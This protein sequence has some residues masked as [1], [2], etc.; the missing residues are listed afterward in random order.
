M[1][2]PA[3]Q[4]AAGA[5]ILRHQVAATQA[6]DSASDEGNQLFQR[7]I[8]SGHPPSKIRRAKE[9]P[10]MPTCTPSRA[11]WAALV[12]AAAVAAGAS[13]A[14]VR[15]RGGPNPELV[16]IEVTDGAG[17]LVFKLQL[18]GAEFHV[19]DGTG[20]KLGSIR[21]EGDRVKAFNPQMKAVGKLKQK[22]DGYK[23]YREPAAAGQ[24]DVEL[25]KFKLEDGRFK[26][27]DAQDRVLADAKEAGG[28][29]KATGAAGQR[30]TVKRKPDGVEVEDAAGK[31]LLRVKGKS[32]PEAALFCVLPGYDT[33]QKAT[34]I[35]WSSRPD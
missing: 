21:K 8:I 34:V 4:G 12:L 30:W 29:A 26:I 35:A 9:E 33:L 3:A 25:V 15:P 14:P 28:G 1:P 17:K 11:P 2:A 5:G 13:A 10:S 32:S 27:K 31:R 19:T 20:R 6:R 24:P 23:L 16:P 22:E 18:Q 7:Q